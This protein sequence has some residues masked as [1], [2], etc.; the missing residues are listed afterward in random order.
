MTDMNTNERPVRVIGAGLAGCEAA[1]VLADRGVRVTLFDMKPGER[2][3]AHSS[4]KLCELVCSNSL[5]SDRL[6]NA[7]GLLKEELRRLSSPVMRAADE[8]RVPAGGALAVDRHRF[9]E[10]ITERVMNHENIDFV[11]GRVDEVGEAPVIVATGPLTDGALMQ[12]LE[13]I[14]GEPLHFF[15]AAAPIVTRESID[16][17]RVFSGSRYD[18]GDDYIN[19]PM[20]AEEYFAF[21]RELQS[22]ETVKLHGFEGKEVFEGCMP[23]EVMAKRGDM[24]LAFGPLKPVGIE[25]PEGFTD[26][27]HKRPYAVVQ[28]RREDKEGTHY[29]LVGFQT[30]LTFPEQ[31]RVFGMIPGLEHAEFTRFGVMHRNTFLNSP[32]KLDRWFSVKNR[33]CM[34]IAGQMTGI[35]GYIESI[36]SGYLAG[37][38][39]YLDLLGK[40]RIDFSRKTAIGALGAYAAEYA[41][42]DFQPQNINFGIME[43]LETRIRVKKER[44]RAVSERALSIIDE[45]AKTL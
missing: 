14:F 1:L 10:L 20:N 11:E 41:G 25:Y 39:M 45:I 13:R 43:Q 4:E 33:P 22:A 32:G 29:N 5:R 2:T 35:E 30:N 17:P 36:A 3:E 34:Y 44:Y 15:D 7:A 26:S 42:S 6:E 27:P 19:C 24:T 8:T 18:R 31:R 16:F 12:D 21:V 37:I 28:L 40:E 23:V 38:S 9:S